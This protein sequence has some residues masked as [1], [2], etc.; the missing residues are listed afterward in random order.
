MWL[1]WLSLMMIATI[2]YFALTGLG[3]ALL[4]VLISASTAVV[5]LGGPGRKSDARLAWCLLGFGSLLSAGGDTLWMWF[6]FVIHTA[7][8]PSDADVVYLSAYISHAAGL[9]MLART[10][11]RRDTGAL[12]DALVV[13]MGAGVLAWVTLITPYASDSSLS[14][15]ARLVSIAYPA[16]DLMLLTLLLR[17]LFA[18]PTR[19]HR[20]L[21]LLA[22]SYTLTLAANVGF[23][24]TS[25]QGTYV[26]GHVIDVGW[27]LGFALAGAAALHPSAYV[28]KPAET[29]APA[30]LLPRSRLVLLA[31]ASLVAPVL[32]VSGGSRHA[33][34]DLMVVGTA[35]GVLFLLVLWRMAGLVRQISQQAIELDALSTTDPLTGVANRRRWDAELQTAIARAQRSGH[36][37]AVV[38]LDLDRFKAFNDTFGHPAG[39]A[40]LEQAAAAWQAQL[41]PGDL[42]AR[43]GGEEFAVLL[44]G[45]RGP[46]AQAVVERL[47][48]ATPDDQ[49]CSAGIAMLEST[50][51]HTTIIERA[52]A[53]LYRAKAEGRNRTVIAHAP[54]VSVSQPSA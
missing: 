38:V 7:P 46:E 24:W 18:G 36:P 49:T 17:L 40:L 42:L 25:L 13:A 51:L 9:V 45:C 27:L 11:G 14:L 20:A 21:T 48:A 47:R 15:V 30:P 44:V 53:A 29:A 28:I 35:S 8:F 6:D 41:R 32:V 52:D 33:D 43:I 37:L 5:F 31:V 34:L 23:G 3:Q 50:D 1:I 2:V 4:Y 26:G 16:C 22:V 39:D 19:R 54:S 12:L 10:V